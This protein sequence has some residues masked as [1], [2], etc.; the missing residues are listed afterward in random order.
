GAEHARP[1]RPAAARGGRRGH[2][3]SRTG[4]AARAAGD[5]R[6]RSRGGGFRGAGAASAA[7]RPPCGVARA[8]D[9]RGAADRRSSLGPR[10][11][12]RGPRARG[13]L[14]GR[15]GIAARGT[16]MARLEFFYDY[17]SPYSYLANGRLPELTARTGAQL[18]YRPM[19]L[20]GVFQA[21]G[22]R[23]PAAETIEAKRRYGEVE[24]SRWVAHLG[25]PFQM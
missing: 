19:L 16:A 5:Q 18:I 24:L 4:D 25:V 7:E 21:T 12:A 3:L 9:P 23:A 2:R 22:N 8:G 15:E 17:G 6:G 20:G 13:R 14:I 11:L 1:G 10:C